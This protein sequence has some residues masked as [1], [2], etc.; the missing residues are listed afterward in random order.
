MFNEDIDNNER[1]EGRD[2]DNNMNE[3]KSKSGLEENK[4]TVE[5][6]GIQRSYQGFQVDKQ[7]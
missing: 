4:K 5:W 1:D 3:N 6:T 2:K 7:I